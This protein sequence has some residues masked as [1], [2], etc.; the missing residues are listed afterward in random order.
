MHRQGIKQRAIARELGI[1]RNTV[2][3]Y[4][5]NPQLPSGQSRSRQRK[6]Q[7][8]PYIDNSDSPPA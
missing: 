2:K 6:S 3:K 4:I 8:D 5:D 1:S 7:L